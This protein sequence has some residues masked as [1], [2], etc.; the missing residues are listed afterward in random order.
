M[1]KKAGLIVFCV[2]SATSNHAGASNQ[3]YAVASTGVAEAQIDDASS[4]DFSYRLN[5]GYEFHRQ[6]QAELGYQR[7]IDDN[8]VNDNNENKAGLSVQALSLSVLGKARNRNGE[9]FY[10]LGLAFVDVEGVFYTTSQNSCHITI[11]T[12]RAT[13]CSANESG[14]GG[15]VGL[16]YDLYVGLRSEVRFEAEYLFGENNVTAAAV[17][18]GYKFKF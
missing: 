12:N 11:E 16:G 18:V 5:I 15:I 14:I 10:R 1:K 9:L 4:T 13:L 8:L 7:L 2:F 6:W 17:Y 3:F